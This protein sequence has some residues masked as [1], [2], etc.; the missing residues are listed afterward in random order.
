LATYNLWDPNNPA[1]E[2]GSVT[3]YEFYGYVNAGNTSESGNNSMLTSLTVATG[4]GASQTLLTD[5]VNDFGSEYMS[6]GTVVAT[7]FFST[8]LDR[9]LAGQAVKL[10]GTGEWEIDHSTTL[11]TVQSSATAN[12]E[13]CE[14]S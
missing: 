10:S 12:H 5:M 6:G 1:N 2:T 11:L 8:D 13:D 3:Q 14:N 4:S 7:G 9:P